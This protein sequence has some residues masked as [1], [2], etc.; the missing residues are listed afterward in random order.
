MRLGT[1]V[2]TELARSELMLSTLFGV[3]DDSRLGEEQL[4]R[5]W[6]RM[7]HES[8]GPGCRK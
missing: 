5:K 3:Y 6:T 1:A 8:G 7:V 2:G 4:R